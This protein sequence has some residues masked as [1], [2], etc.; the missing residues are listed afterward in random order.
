ML[1]RLL[2]QMSGADVLA[3]EVA[4]LSLRLRKT[5]SDLLHLQKRCESAG[6]PST[7]DLPESFVYGRRGSAS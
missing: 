6:L 3:R 1:R 2:A 7:T 5:E 4:A